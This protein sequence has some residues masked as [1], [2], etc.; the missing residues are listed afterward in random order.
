MAAGCHQFFRYSPLGESQGAVLMR[1]K[2]WVRPDMVVVPECHTFQHTAAIH[3]DPSLGN[4]YGVHNLFEHLIA[5]LTLQL[6][7]GFYHDAVAKRGKH[8]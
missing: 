3:K 1:M 5:V 4:L 8:G 6:C 7:F 2:C